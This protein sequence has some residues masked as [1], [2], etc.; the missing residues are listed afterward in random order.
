MICYFGSEIFSK[1]KGFALALAICNQ[2][3][4]GNWPRFFLSWPTLLPP[5]G[6]A[7]G[8]KERRLL[9]GSRNKLISFPFSFPIRKRGSELIWNNVVTEG[10]STKKG[11]Q[12]SFLSQL[13][14]VELKLELVCF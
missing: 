8:A 14:E 11:E 1:T 9:L 6:V 5:S 7:F 13:L 3:K 2:K 10:A 12:N 4:E